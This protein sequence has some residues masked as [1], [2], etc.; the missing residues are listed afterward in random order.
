MTQWNVKL[1]VASARAD[2]LARVAAGGWAARPPIQRGTTWAPL[3]MDRHV[4]AA[5][6]ATSTAIS[7]ADCPPPTT[8]T[9]RPAK[10]AGVR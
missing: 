1:G 3:R 6:P 8:S 7:A 5:T 10:G 2:R 9:R 4:R